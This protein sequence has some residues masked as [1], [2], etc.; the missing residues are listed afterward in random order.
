MR[1]P[2]P[3]PRRPAGPPGPRSPTFP[4]DPPAPEPDH[5]RRPGARIRRSSRR[6]FRSPNLS[7]SA[8]RESCGPPGP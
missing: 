3:S 2:E 7:A 4:I 1:M 8:D 5:A 6:R